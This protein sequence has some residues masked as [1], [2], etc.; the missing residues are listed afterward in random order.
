MGT[1]RGQPERRVLFPK[2]DFPFQKQRLKRSPVTMAGKRVHEVALPLP[3]E[4]IEEKVN[5]R[6]RRTWV[7]V[8]ETPAFR[9][10]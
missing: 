10:G 5:K 8:L 6:T 3:G 9:S 1:A 2:P 4:G 7:F